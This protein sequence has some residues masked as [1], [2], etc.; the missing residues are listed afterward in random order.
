MTS[1]LTVE[2]L[3]TA[4][5][6]WLL[7]S[8]QDHFAMEIDVLKRKDAI[9]DSSCLLPGLLCVG[10]RAENSKASYSNQHPV[11]L[12]GKHQVTKLIACSEHVK[13]LHAGHKLLTSMLS[14]HFRIV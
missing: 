13:L 1:S 3:T 9:P 12:Y 14:H 10:G 6:Y 8:Q 11:I 4:E 5:T 2:D 7:I